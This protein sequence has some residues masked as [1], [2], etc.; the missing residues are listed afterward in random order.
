MV[1]CGGQSK[2]RK[3]TGSHYYHICCWLCCFAGGHKWVVGM[4]GR[5]PVTMRVV[6][7]GQSCEVGGERRSG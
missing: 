4:E 1:V 7:G 5:L 2:R 6:L 3:V